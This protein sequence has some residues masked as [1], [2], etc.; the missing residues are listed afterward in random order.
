MGEARVLGGRYRLVEPL[1]SGG[2]SVVWKGYDE[3]LGRAVAVKVLHPGHAVDPDARDRIRAEAQ[4]A[5]RLAH[6]YITAVHDFGESGSGVPYVVMELV[7]GPT[8]AD[9][10]DAGPVPA[11]DTLR[12]CAQI[13]AALTAAHARGVVH[14]DI[15]PVNVMLPASG[16]KVL[17][18]G[19]SAVAGEH[20]PA[21][22][23]RSVWGTPAYLAPERIDGGAVTPASD[24]YALG[25]LLYRLLAGAPPWHT[26]SIA[27]LFDAHRFVAPAPL[28]ADL[29]GV[30]DAVRRLCLACLAKDPRDRPAT[31][32]VAKVLATAAGRP[33][34]PARAPAGP[35]AAVAPAAVPRATDGV[36]QAGRPTGAE[37]RTAVRAVPV[38]SGLTARRTRRGRAPAGLATAVAAT[39]ALGFLSAA[40]PAPP[41]AGQ[42][43]SGDTTQSSST[44][45]DDDAKADSNA[46]YTGVPDLS[47]RIAK[48]TRSN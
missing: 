17:D 15:K 27:D 18:F 16:V 45:P 21:P 20:E 35:R 13:A 10:I 30:P 47:S 2:M 12:I 36:A 22:D 32:E 34:A 14:R 37:P 25:L 7:T 43:S 40:A 1:G 29:P 41:P 5:A 33:P 9:R 39:L 44:L 48:I 38:P 3:V 6:P 24:V 11:A 4:R 8:L 42:S 23:G 31:A 28:P 46:R 19:I 26:E